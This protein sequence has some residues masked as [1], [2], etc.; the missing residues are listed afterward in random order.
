MPTERQRGE[1]FYPVY[2]PELSLYDVWLLAYAKERMKDEVL[3][4]EDVNPN[5]FDRCPKSEK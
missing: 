5:L 4:D 3:S 1:F 2:S